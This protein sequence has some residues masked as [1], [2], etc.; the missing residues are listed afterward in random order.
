[1][2]VS[3]G[4]HPVSPYTNTNISTVPFLQMAQNLNPSGTSRRAKHK[5]AYMTGP[6]PPRQLNA[7][8]GAL[9]DTSIITNPGDFWGALQINSYGGVI[10]SVPEDATPIHQRSSILKLLYQVYWTYESTD[11]QNLAWVRTFY[12][13]MYGQSGPV[14]DGVMDGCYVNYPDVDLPDWAYLYY[15]NNYPRLQE[16]KGQ[17]DPHNI[18]NHPQSIRRK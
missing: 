14:P 11:A 13:S 17:W 3:I 2:C 6:F 4:S 12:L 9:R 1:M 10:N 7:M 8:W 15:K 16:V 18:F 5:S